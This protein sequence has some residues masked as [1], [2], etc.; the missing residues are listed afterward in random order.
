LHVFLQFNNVYST[1]TIP[2]HLHL[3]LVC[4]LDPSHC[5]GTHWVA[6]YVDG[7]YA[8]YFDLIGRAQLDVVRNHLSWWC[9]AD[10]WL[11]ND[12]QLQCHQSTLWT[13]LHLLLCTYRIFM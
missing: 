2:L 7:E 5:P 13:L 10:R 1:D 9:G 6:I 3:L 11:Y 8:E 12:Y 4:I